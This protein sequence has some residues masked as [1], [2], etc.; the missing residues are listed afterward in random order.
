MLETGDPRGS[1]VQFGLHAG[2]HV[3]EEIA[4]AFLRLQ[5]LEVARRA[6]MGLSELD[7]YARQDALVFGVP[8]RELLVPG[9]Q[10]IG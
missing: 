4:L 7:L 10:R 1:P 3:V 9:A 5:R 8:L 2:E 6:R